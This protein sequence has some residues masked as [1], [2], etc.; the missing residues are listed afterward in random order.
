MKERK[1]IVVLVVVVAIVFCC[2][3][4]YVGAI[5]Y[6]AIDNN[7]TNA[8]PE[9]QALSNL[10]ERI[11]QLKVLKEEQTLTRDI[12]VIQQQI[13]DLSAVAPIQSVIPK[14]RLPEELQE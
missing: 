3:G 11:G 10:K 1:T 4:G 2:L 7:Q 5:A 9:G 12:M 6:I 8:V 13:R 14:E